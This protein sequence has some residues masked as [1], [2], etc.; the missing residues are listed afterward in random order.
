MKLTRYQRMILINQFSI[1]AKLYPDEAENY[2]KRI[3]VLQNGY[4]RHYE[5]LIDMG[6]DMSE[7]ACSEILN[8]LDMF[9]MIHTSLKNCANA[10]D[11]MRKSLQ[12]RGFDGNEEPDQY[13]Y[14]NYLMKDEGRYPWLAAECGDSFLNSHIPVLDMYRRMYAKWLELG[15][16]QD[17][18]TDLLKKISDARLA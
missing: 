10:T 8:I 17:M 3:K 12:F 4:S 7:E 14:A 2:E 18:D 6:E 11:D 9:S 13:S 16:P 1:L 15:K 5:W